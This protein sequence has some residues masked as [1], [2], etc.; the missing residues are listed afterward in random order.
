MAAT[1]HSGV[2]RGRTPGRWARAAA[3]AAA[4]LA[5]AVCH[6]AGPNT[7]SG[8]NPQAIS[9]PSGPG[10]IRGIGEDFEPTLNTG[11]AKY[12]IALDLP[13]G[14]A[15]FTPEV[16]FRYDSGA[17]NGIL[18]FGWSLDM[19]HVRRR[20][21]KPLPRYSDEPGPN[22]EPA[23]RYVSDLHD[24]PMGLVP[25]DDGHYFGEREG[26]FVRYWRDGDAWEARE[27]DGVTMRFGDSPG[28]RIAHPEGLGDYKWC[29]EERRDLS[30][31]TI[32]YHYAAFED[33]GSANQ[34]YLDS[35][36]YGAGPPPWDAFHFVKFVYE[37]RA[38]VIENCRAG[39]CIVTGMRLAS[40]I[41]GTQGVAL[42][43]H[44]GG[45]FNDDGEPDHLVRRYDLAYEA[46]DHWS[47]LT[48]VTLVG[49]DGETAMPPM[50]MEYTLAE[51]PDTADARDAL[52]GAIN[53]PTRLFDN[54][55]VEVTELNGDGL[56]DLLETNLLGGPHKAYVNEGET[57]SGADRAVRWSGPVEI[58]GDARA[59]NV[60]LGG[61]D[62]VKTHLSDLDGDGRADLV[63]RGNQF[64][65]FYFPQRVD[66]ATGNITWGQRRPMNLDLGQVAPPSPELDDVLRVDV[67]DD[68]LADIVQAVDG[69]S[70][71]QMRV[72]IN[73]GGDRYLPPYTL[74]TELGFSF[75]QAGV[76]YVDFN[77]DGIPDFV[78]LSTG[79]IQ[80]A[81]GLGHG[82]LGDPVYFAVE[83][84][85]L[86]IPQI[87]RAQF[88]D[89]TGNGLPDLVIER[90][91]A[92][93]LWYWANLGHYAVDHRRV[94][95][96]LPAPVSVNA[97]ARWAD[98]NGN[99]STDL[100]YADAQASPRLRIIDLGELIGAVPAPNLLTAIE[101][102]IGRRIEISHRSSGDFALADR[103]AGNPWPDPM[104]FTVD[105]VDR[106]T[107][108]DGLGGEYNM[109]YRYGGGFYDPEH[110]LFAGFTDVVVEDEGEETAPTEVLRHRFSVGRDF[111]QMAGVL[112]RVSRE[113]LDGGV[114]V[115]EEQAWTPRVLHTADAGQQ[116]VF[117]RLDRKDKIIVEQGAGDPVTFR[118]TF[119]YDDYGNVVWS[120]ENPAYDPG[121]AEPPAGARALETEYAI[122]EDLWLVRLRRAE[123]LYAGDLGG[124]L[125]QRT[126]YF[127]DDEDFT[128]VQG[129]LTRGLETMVR[130][131]H[132]PADDDGYVIEKRVRYDAH[133]NPVVLI[134]GAA[135]VDDPTDPDAGHFREVAYDGDFAAFPV[136]E[137][138]HIGVGADPLTVEAEYN[139]GLGV[140]TAAIGFGGQRTEYGYDAFGR[141]TRT[142]RPGDDPDYPSL[143]YVYAPAVEIDGVGVVNYVETRLLDRWPGGAAAWIDHYNRA[144]EYMDGMGRRLMHRREAGDDP[145]TGAPRVSVAHAATFNGRGGIATLIEPH[146]TA[147][148]GDLDALLAF[149]SVAAPGWTGLF[150]E[151]G[152][153]A[154]RDLDSAHQTRHTYD[155]MQRERVLT[156]PD[157]ALNE[158]RYVVLATRV[159]DDP[160]L[161]P[162]SPFFDTPV[163]HRYDAFGRLAGVDEVTRAGDGATLETWSTRY[164]HRADDVLLRIV[165]AQG[166]VKTWE[167][168]GIGRRVAMDDHNRGRVQWTHDGAGNLTGILDARGNHTAFLYDGANRKIAEYD[169]GASD[170]FDPAQPIGEDN[171]PRVAWFHDT[172]A[173]PLDLGGGEVVEAEHTRG[174]LAYVWDEAGETHQSHDA[175]GNLV[176]TAVRMPD[177][178]TGAPTWHRTSMA[179]DAQ[180]RLAELAYPDGDRAT[181]AYTAGGQL[182]ELGGGPGGFL[183]RG[184]DYTPSDKPVRREH[185]NGVVAAFAFDARQR[186]LRARAWNAA[187]PDAP[188]FDQG[189]AYDTASN[190]TAIDDLRPAAVVA[191]DDPRRNT[192]RLDYDDRNRLV[193]ARLSFGLPGGDFAE[194]GRLNYAF[195]R[196]GNLT[197]QTSGLDHTDRGY[198]VADLGPIAY[199]GDAGS[200]GRVGRAADDP[201]GPHA[202]TRVGDGEAAREIAYDAN[203]NVSAFDGFT[204]THD[205]RD[206]LVAVEDASMRA[207]YTYNHEG[208]RALKRVW[209]KDGDGALSP[210]PTDAV[211]YVDRHF[212]VRRN[213]QATKYVYHGG[214]RIAKITGTLDPD[215]ARAQW[216]RLQAGWNVVALAVDAA[217]AT[218]QLGLG[219][220]PA[221]GA[222]FMIDP[223]SGEAVGVGSDMPLP[224]GSVL[225]I[226]AGEARTLR[227]IG[228]HTPPAAGA[229]AQR[230]FVAPG[231]LGP[232]A[233]DDALPPG[234]GPVWTFDAP[235]Q[236]WRA[237]AGAELPGLDELPPVLLPGQPV[238]L[239][240]DAPAVL[241]AA[242]PDREILY[243]HPDHIDSTAVLTDAVGAVAEEI[244]Y[245]PYG[246][247]RNI[248]RAGPPVENPYQF[249]QKERDRETGLHYFEARYLAGP[250][251]R[252]LQ[253]DPVAEAPP[254]AALLDP[255]ALQ[256]YGYGRGNPLTYRDPTG[257]FLQTAVA[258]AKIREA[259]PYKDSDPANKGKSMAERR[260]RVFGELKLDKGA[261]LPKGQSV[262]TSVK[263]L[264]QGD[265]D[266]A[267]ES[268]TALSNIAQFAESLGK[269]TKAGGKGKV[270]TS[271]F[272]GALT[273]DRKVGG[274]V[275]DGANL[276]EGGRI[277]LTGKEFGEKFGNKDIT[278]LL[279]GLDFEKKFEELSGIAEKSLERKGFSFDMKD[280][281]SFIGKYLDTDGGGSGGSKDSD[282]GSKG[283]S[284]SSARD[285]DKDDSDDD[286]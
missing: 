37:E 282:S 142:W 231:G 250:L 238:Y 83:D 68:K 43:G 57:G 148:A 128:G 71:V 228:A 197:A 49:A 198:P 46:H 107:V 270:D 109:F 94:V 192:Q 153:L 156:L 72:W 246:A 78:R 152:A 44:A 112:E 21:F 271:E 113:T 234:V 42:P 255:Q 144:R 244:A 230:G 165:D 132:D 262:S 65:V 97:A 104:P 13:R 225:W 183:L 50:R 20:D 121:A 167:Y 58:G 189:Y 8:V 117:P 85:L 286:T 182:A 23:D 280:V 212:E 223:D 6:A 82:A 206:R 200:S 18:G 91:A 256:A 56:P 141:L 108:R 28:A 239:H 211:A 90:A 24:A 35:I 240:L 14:P 95:T 100:A 5:G 150:H 119:G 201:P 69:G 242:S 147:L 92:G 31:N 264:L 247:P 204:L 102:G 209:S 155:A 2:R 136:A 171:R 84:M 77:G 179:Y 210:E 17:G 110:K 64:S 48:G 12:D 184:L 175:R 226:Q 114:F 229:G 219:T 180:D 52:I 188:I 232:I 54:D 138:I 279:D 168:D 178:R 45:D 285:S 202:A 166:N 76:H 79:G 51:L 19:P 145:D 164:A 106:V 266:K 125:V 99:G 199:G 70:V 146:Y 33:E 191:A 220:D 96:N 273:K 254:E 215:R 162:A 7:S 284:K 181:Y 25:T 66:P 80:V 196:L 133:G 187:A 143:E 185:G 174:R 111:F 278:K 120:R 159:Y 170:G 149:E 216:L 3:I 89:I 221:I 208:R 274:A 233:L 259:N 243:Y 245:F 115:V 163:A 29:I 268:N 194:D 252:F 222:A 88:E 98:F 251:A 253:V 169:P 40:V 172:P 10:T 283:G 267:Q 36:A 124:D 137:V 135:P 93:E 248:H 55:N 275:P 127:H 214:Q 203:G 158:K 39:F 129:P 38:D 9:L 131:Y 126:E 205:A 177:P 272:L 34:L 217:D 22:G 190:M 263:G 213:D 4:G 67:N 140:V 134:D 118:T 59:W 269:L 53:A 41:I 261:K 258:K 265:I 186:M 81:P 207:E 160:D 236:A 193:A 277:V 224:A 139:P 32:R 15:G 249:A 73:L 30:G 130:K 1:A 218:A 63:M 47:L 176:W 103:Q 74:D 11:T 154:A 122:D 123:R 173:G 157:G 87:A 235:T 276:T 60:A 116:V 27:P 227:V 101:N 26:A 86:T 195:D 241:G 75:S 161:D 62:G 61:P 16:G 257:R 237:R 151:D 281:E 260:A 105:V